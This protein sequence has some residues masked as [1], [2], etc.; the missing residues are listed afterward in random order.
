M[1]RI[2]EE[3]ACCRSQVYNLIGD[4]LLPDLIELSSRSRGLTLKEV[5]TVNAARIAGKSAKEIR[6]IV[7]MLM[8]DRKTFSVDE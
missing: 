7:K 2:T 6:A 4:G 1:H 8:E 3:L 5:E